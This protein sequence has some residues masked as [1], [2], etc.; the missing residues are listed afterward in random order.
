M[1]KEVAAALQAWGNLTGYSGP[2]EHL[3]LVLTAARRL[4]TAHRQIERVR[5][6]LDHLKE[7]RAN[8]M[9]R[10]DATLAVLGDA[11]LAMIIGPQA[12]LNG[13]RR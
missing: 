13:S 3:W 11:Q 5:E 4:D 12:Q 7:P 2:R 8:P 9:R 1:D 6:G 10:A